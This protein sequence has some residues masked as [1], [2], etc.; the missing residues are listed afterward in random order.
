MANEAYRRLPVLNPHFTLHV[1]ER[2]EERFP[3]YDLKHEF[4]RAV[5]HV[6]AK[7]QETVKYMC[8]GHVDVFE[9]KLFAGQYLRRT[10]ENTIFIIKDGNVVVTVL[11]CSEM[12]MDEEMQRKDKETCNMI[13]PRRKKK[14]L[15][16]N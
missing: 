16:R 6:G 2:F 10:P 1:T 5:L 4:G 11:D 9:S 13:G 14:S 3:E 12:E 7:M 8:Y 15:N